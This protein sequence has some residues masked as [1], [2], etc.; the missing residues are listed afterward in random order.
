MQPASWSQFGGNA[1]SSADAAL[2][3]KST[4]LSILQ[5]VLGT[6]ASSSEAV[7]SQKIPNTSPNLHLPQGDL[8]QSALERNLYISTGG[9]LPELLDMWIYFHLSV[10]NFRMHFWLRLGFQ[11]ASAPLLVSLLGPCGAP[12]GRLGPLPNHIHWSSSL[13]S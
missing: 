10:E 9:G 2:S 3:K 13:S 8:S 11:A 7:V 1:S 6:W 4:K 5:S 12:V